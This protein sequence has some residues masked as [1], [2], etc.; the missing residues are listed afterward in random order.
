MAVSP[1]LFLIGRCIIHFNISTRHDRVLIN[2]YRGELAMAK[3]Q[4]KTESKRILDMMINSIYTHKEVFLRELISNASDA[5]D[6]RYFNSITGGAPVAR[7][8]LQIQ[9]EVDRDARRLTIRD[10]GCGMTKEELIDNLGT[11]ARSGTLQFKQEHEEEA[12]EIIGQFGVGFYSAFMVSRQITVK[13][14]AEGAEAA[15]CWKSSGEDGYTIDVCEMEG[16]GTEIALEISADTEEEKYS[17]FLDAYTI[18]SL[19]K[20]YSDYIHFPIRMEMERR[21]KKENSDE[22]ETYTEVETLNSMVPIWKKAKGEVTDEDY[23]NFYRDKFFDFADPV[24]VIQTKVEG[25]VTFG[26]LLF[27]P[28][29]LPYDYYTKNYKKGLQLYCNGVMIMENCAELLPDHFGF[30]KG[31]VDSADFS[32]NISREMLQH[33]RQLKLI[34]K[35]IEKKITSELKKM[36]ADEREKY[37]E[38]FRSF[39]LQIKYG[40]YADFG[41]KKDELQE[42]ALF[43]ALAQDKL[44]TLREYRDAMPDAQEYIYYACGETA[45]KIGA[46]PQ[47][48][49]IRDKGYDILCLTEDVDEFAIKTLREYDGKAFKSVSDSELGL[50]TE[51]QKAEIQK[52]TEDNKALIEAMQKA[53][54]GKVKEVR[55]SARL[56]K[57]PVCLVSGGELSLDMEKVLNAMPAEQKVKAERVLELNAAHPVFAALARAEGEEKI[58][59]YARLLYDQALL[60][61]GMPIEDPVEFSNSICELMQ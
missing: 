11:I 47:T 3:R 18:S 43:H 10:N 49:A 19:V 61:A 52:K 59:K 34:A 22:Y 33:D 24:R 32:L 1:L 37:E 20:K 4:F 36:L 57:H 16:C 21:R 35:T 28:A 17:Q 5:L 15:Y 27:I 55:L 23:N 29:N 58:A 60:I 31:V 54:E 12:E 13:S 6:K 56:T 8:E 2:R 9:I 41:A 7:E 25:S 30:V 53:L 44:V 40:I 50:E 46:L 51:E 38:F 45:A 39:G 42:L 14:R 48:E 26:A